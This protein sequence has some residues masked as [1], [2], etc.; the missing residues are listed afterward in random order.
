MKAGIVGLVL[1]SAFFAGCGSNPETKGEESAQ[2]KAK[3]TQ[4]ESIAA[5][6]RLG[7]WFIND[8]GKELVLIN[9]AKVTD[10][11]LVH[12]EGMTGMTILSLRGTKVT[13]AGLVHL[14]GMT[15]LHV[16][17]LSNTKITDAGVAKLK[18]VLPDCMIAN[19][20][21]KDKDKDDDDDD[22]RE[23][24]ERLELE[25]PKIL[26]KIRGAWGMSKEGYIEMLT[27]HYQGLAAMMKKQIAARADAEFDKGVFEFRDGKAKIYR[28]RDSAVD[29]TIKFLSA[30]GTTGEFEIT[31]AIGSR[32]PSE[33]EGKVSGDELILN[34]RKLIRLNDEESARR[35]ESIKNFDPFTVPGHRREVQAREMQMIMG[36]SR[37]LKAYSIDHDGAYPASLDDPNFLEESEMRGVLEIKDGKTGEV[38]QPWYLKGQSAAS[39]AG[40]I[41]IAS[42][43][44]YDETRAV[45]FCDFSGQVIK[46]GRFQEELAKIL[47]SGG[48][49]LVK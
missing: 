19:A 22:D 9:A 17:N 41:L 33:W 36:L 38:A 25:G 27:Q 28:P 24:A 49:E 32:L 14:E 3:P 18:A 1:V 6:E 43:W 35:K 11:G 40:E 46:E 47:E 34:G 26:K 23:L 7:A 2:D 30:D 29:H 44:V 45:V 48:R 5:I 37:T 13:D 16:L 21:D 39:L 12:L 31:L 42:P 10:A 4:A 8:D 20:N 15:G